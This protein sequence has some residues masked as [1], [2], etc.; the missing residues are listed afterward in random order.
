MYSNHATALNV[1]TTV[2]D[3]NIS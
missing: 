3:I 1:Q 2:L